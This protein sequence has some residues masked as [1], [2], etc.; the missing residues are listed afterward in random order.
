MPE[1]PEAEATR[2]GSPRSTSPG[3]PP[4]TRRG[5]DEAMRRNR[6][7]VAGR[8]GRLRRHRVGDLGPPRGCQRP[9]RDRG[10]PHQLRR[11]HRGADLRDPRRGGWRVDTFYAFEGAAQARPRSSSTWARPRAARPEPA[12]AHLWS[13]GLGQRGAAGGDYPGERRGRNSTSAKSLPAI[14]RSTWST[15]ALSSRSRRLGDAGH[16]PRHLRAVPAGLELPRDA[17]RVGVDPGAQ[18]VEPPQAAG[19]RVGRR[20]G[21]DLGDR[22]DALGVREMEQPVGHL[23]RR[24]SHA[25]PAP[26]APRRGRP[27]R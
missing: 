5:V 10:R 1:V 14:P 13:E 24:R 3:S 18:Q 20:A 15:I 23:R 12:S 22:L 17:H 9:R 6:P 19:E 27:P 26:A 11:R 21:P 8:G 2:P 7:G 16:H 4:V 25:R